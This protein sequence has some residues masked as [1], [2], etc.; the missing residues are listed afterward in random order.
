MGYRMDRP[1]AGLSEVDRRAVAAS[2]LFQVLAVG[3]I[4]FF[5]GAP[6]SIVFAS[7]LGGLIAGALSGN[8]EQEYM[9]GMVAAVIGVLASG[10]LGMGLLYYLGARIDA[11]LAGEFLL[12][13]MLVVFAVVLFG[14]PLVMLAGAMGGFI[15]ASLVDAFG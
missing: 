4:L 6:E 11:V 14:L 12:L 8:Y 5:S 10:A 3:P 15:G 7:I 9:D 13:G 2:V 1:K